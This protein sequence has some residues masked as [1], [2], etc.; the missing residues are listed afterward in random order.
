MEADA[1]TMKPAAE[2]VLYVSGLSK[3][4]RRKG[5]GWQRSEVVIAA[6]EVEFEI[7]SGQTLALVG[8]SG[9]GKSTVAR[10][11]TRL[12]KPDSGQ[13]WLEGAD[14]AQFDSRQLRPL[15]P[16]LQMVFQDPTTSLNPRF[17]AAE[18]IE[19][20]LVIQ[21]QSD[22]SARRARA[23]ELMQ[24]VGLSPQWADRSAM[25][26]S[27]GQRQRLA[28]ARAIALK[29]K[30]LVL[31]EALSGLDLSTEAQIANLLLDL[32]SSHSLA[33]L[34]ISHDLALV[35]RLADTIAVMAKGEIVEQGLTSQVISNASHPETRALCASTRAAQASLSALGVTP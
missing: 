4:Y 31:D 7:F 28:I 14:I 18:V 34:L 20:P 15:R 16:R 33:Y 12:E 13:I 1:S 30:L 11:V 2:R 8:S 25:D 27:G 17:S 22:K 35:A 23:K 24:E 3:T 32:Q 6:S 9:S 10:C 29:P 26:F 21:G 19:E 5:A